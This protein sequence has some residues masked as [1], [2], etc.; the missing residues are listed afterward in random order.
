MN[1]VARRGLSM[2]FT[3]AAALVWA[4]LAGGAWLIGCGHAD[5]PAPQAA[6]KPVFASASVPAAELD[7]AARRD[8]YEA[9]AKML[10]SNRFPSAAECGQC[11][12]TQFRQWSVSQHSYAQLSPIFN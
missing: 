10:A 11:H 1:H 12:P 3:C 9:H 4:A 2:R 6:V 5:S 7:D 8:P